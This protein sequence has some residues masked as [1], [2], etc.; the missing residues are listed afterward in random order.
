M[1][2]KWKILIGLFLNEESIILMEMAIEY[3][4]NNLEKNSIL[5]FL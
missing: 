3:A 5:Q 2:N 4:H 1:K